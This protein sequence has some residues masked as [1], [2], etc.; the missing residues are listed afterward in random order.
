MADVHSVAPRPDGLVVT[1]TG[2]DA[3]LEFVDGQVLRHDLADRRPGDFTRVPYPSLKPHA[4]HPNYASMRGGELWVTRFEDRCARSLSGLE[5]SLP[6]GPPHDGHLR[7]GLVWYTT[8]T[9]HVVA[10]DPSSLARVEYYDLNA[11]TQ[12]D[13]ILGWCRG[14]EVVGS[15]VYVGMT[16][17]RDTRHREVLRWVSRGSAGRQL[18]TRVVEFERGS[19]RILREFG[20]GNR[21]G[22]TIHG[23]L[24][25]P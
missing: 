16:Q 3:V 14:V 24:A 20:L 12:N 13:G 21:A 1:S 8:V 11:L 2:I 5:V 15:R 6:E 25:L 23:L 19:G 10:V 18:P 17:L 4:V 7:D 9:G 22:G